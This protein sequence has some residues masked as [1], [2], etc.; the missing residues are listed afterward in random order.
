MSNITAKSPS[1]LVMTGARNAFASLDHSLLLGLMESFGATKQV[2]TI[3]EQYLK[4]RTQFV[5]IE[6]ER[7]SKWSPE[8]GIYAGSVLSGVLFSIGT[9]SQIINKPHMTNFADDSG[10]RVE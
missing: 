10:A 8:A 9:A 6:D 5:Q 4:R 1:V 2:T 7:S 3:I